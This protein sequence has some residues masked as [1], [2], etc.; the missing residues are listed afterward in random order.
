MINAVWIRAA[1]PGC[2]PMAS[3]AAATARPCPNPQRPEAIAIPTPAAMTANG[4]IHPPPAVPASAASARPGN[5]S[6]AIPAAI[7]ERR[8]TVLLCVWGL[9]VMRRL[10]FAP[11]VLGLLDGARDVE[12]R[13]HHEDERL[14]ERHQ[15]LERIQE[16]D[17]E[18]DHDHAAD[19]ADDRAER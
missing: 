8:T 4:P 15:D 11:V 1:A 5:A 12:H 16:P 3:T 13:E 6:T 18:D 10:V 2:R 17:G 14:K 9:L 19:A 7:S